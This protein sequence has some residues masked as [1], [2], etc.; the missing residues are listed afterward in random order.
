M[1]RILAALLAAA[2]V[3]LGVT[4]AAGA[5]PVDGYLVVD[6]GNTGQIYTLTQLGTN[7]TAVT[8]V[9]NGELA[10]QPRWSPDGR[11]IAFVRIGNGPDRMYTM[12]ADGSDVHLVLRDGPRWNDSAPDYFPDGNRIV[13]A[14]CQGD[15]SGCVVTTVGV[16]GTGLQ[17]LTQLRFEVYDAAPT[18]SPDGA[19][20]AFIRFNADGVRSRLWV[21]NTDGSAGHPVTPPALEPYVAAW[22]PDSA[23]LLTASD[24]CRLGGDLYSIN[25]ADG[26]R[27]R[28]THT[29]YPNFSGAGVYAPSGREIAFNT[30][31]NYPDKCC[32]DLYLMRADGEH[33]VKVNTGLK[34]IRSI[35]WG[36]SPYA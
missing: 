12:A 2:A 21:M 14:R 3:I 7:V 11:R 24:C 29:P 5:S 1:R 9:P 27:T 16:D 17:Q 26:S 34:G 19:H 6:D 4:T 33:Q 23:S 20:I 28:L 31:R 18:V 10:I 35:D 25:L 15:G 22:S 13:F 32:L 36:P 30:D 8:D